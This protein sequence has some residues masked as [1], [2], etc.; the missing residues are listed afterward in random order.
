[1]VAERVDIAIIGGG[2]IGSAIACTLAAQPGFSGSIVVLERDP[3]Y[4]TAA[5][6]LSVSS[7][8]QQFSTPINI[9]L[10]L[11]SIAFL[12]Q[13]ARHLA[14]EGEPAPD[15]AL[16]EPGYLFRSLRRYP[17]IKSIVRP[18]RLE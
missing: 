10:S 17:H 7:I 13:A 11:H 3:S 6:A 5:S 8:R 14:V 2:V 15:I 1:M 16:K 4:R 18:R 9:A 12:R